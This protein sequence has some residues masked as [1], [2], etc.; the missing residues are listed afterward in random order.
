MGKDEKGLRQKN[1]RKSSEIQVIPFASPEPLQ[2]LNEG[3]L[4]P[5]RPRSSKRL[6]PGKQ[7]PK[8]AAKK[9]VP[10]DAISCISDYSVLSNIDFQPRNTPPGKQSSQG[11]TSLLTSKSLMDFTNSPEGEFEIS[12]MLLCPQ[13]V[14]VVSSSLKYKPQRIWKSPNATGWHREKAAPA[15]TKKKFLQKIHVV[16]VYR[17]AQCKFSLQRFAAMSNRVAGLTWGCETP[18]NIFCH[19]NFAIRVPTLKRAFLWVYFLSNR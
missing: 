17:L 6:L 3:K 1:E 19:T 16:P 10:L 13:T 18:N 8:S 12:S 14:N 15:R 4:L 5:Q 7:P 2:P 11:G 9:G